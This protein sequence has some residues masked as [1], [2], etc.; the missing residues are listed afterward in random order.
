M[1]NEQIANELFESAKK[2]SPGGMSD[3]TWLPMYM[4]RSKLE[5]TYYVMGDEMQF[6]LKPRGTR[7]A[8]YALSVNRNS[9]TQIDIGKVPANDKSLQD[10][11]IDETEL[12]M[13]KRFLVA[14]KQALSEE[15]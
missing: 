3:E 9:F 1:N 8:R 2:L 10:V 5:L 4:G 6:M 11:S 7:F 13:A 15:D 12:Q 14:V